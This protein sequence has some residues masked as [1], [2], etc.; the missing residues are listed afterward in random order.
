MNMNLYNDKQEILI[1]FSTIQNTRIYLDF[2]FL[3]KLYLIDRFPKHLR[4]VNI[5]SCE[6]NLLL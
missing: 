1:A 4:K 5:N 2:N 6:R 3:F